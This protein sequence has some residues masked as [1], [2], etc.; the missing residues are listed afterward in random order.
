MKRVNEPSKQAKFGFILYMPHDRANIALPIRG[1]VG[2]RPHRGQNTDA[3]GCGRDRPTHCFI[4]VQVVAPTGRPTDRRH[5]RIAV[6]PN[7][8]GRKER[9]SY[10]VCP[11]ECGLYSTAQVSQVRRLS[12]EFVSVVSVRVRDRHSSIIPRSRRPRPPP[13]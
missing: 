3:D 12:T 1:T 10:S 6:P 2:S 5:R 13:Q 4:L 11:S 8:E 9:L 7:K